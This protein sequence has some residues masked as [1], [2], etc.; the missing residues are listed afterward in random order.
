M[1][2][3]F[4]AASSAFACDAAANAATN[5]KAANP[6]YALIRLFQETGAA[7]QGGP[8]MFRPLFLDREDPERAAGGHL[9]ETLV[10]REQRI[11]AAHA[12]R[13]AHHLP[14]LL[15]PAAHLPP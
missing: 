8:A 5:A 6:W 12:P 9:L 10:A 1:A 13:H 11:D 7:R 14:P 3:L 2:A 4:C 15:L